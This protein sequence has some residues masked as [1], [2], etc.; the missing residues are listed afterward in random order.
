MG[1]SGE[2]G[3]PHFCQIQCWPGMSEGSPSRPPFSLRRF[4]KLSIKRRLS[5]HM[6]R[7]IKTQTDRFGR[8]LRKLSGGRNETSSSTDN[9][10]T[11]SLRSGDMVLI[12]S[13]EEIKATLNF[14][15]ELKGCLFMQDMWQYC[16]TS[17]QVFKS[18]NR[19]VDE[20]DYRVKKAKGL[21]LLEGLV[22]EGAP[23]YGRCDRACFYFWREEW[24]E[25]II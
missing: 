3:K 19:Y 20:R 7:K 15:G 21:V 17:Q 5:P 12:R 18:V 13:N 22:C 8:W 23:D 1:L 25:K 16:G 11:S 2:D 4:I 6:K 10:G 24:L 14:W 9:S